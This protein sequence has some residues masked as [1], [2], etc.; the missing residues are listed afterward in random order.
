MP[1]QHE[2]VDYSPDP[3]LTPL[4]HRVINLLAAGHSVTHAAQTEQ[5][6]RNT[7]ANWRRT[8]PAFAREIENA[9]REHYLQSQEQVTSLLPLAIAN[10]REIVTSDTAPLSLKFRASLAILKMAAQPAPLAPPAE[11]GSFVPPA[12]NPE[13][14]H[15]SAQSCTTPPELGSFVPH[16]PQPEIVHNSAQS[17]TTNKPQPIRV[18]PQPGRNSPC[19]CASGLKFKRCCAN[20]PAQPALPLA[21]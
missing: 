16:A 9:T 1:S 13:N 11:L 18:P 3:T 2:L 20:K 10:I 14:L 21:S 7:I 12:P 6:H 15:N 5:I 8:V 19:P 4:Q 17:C